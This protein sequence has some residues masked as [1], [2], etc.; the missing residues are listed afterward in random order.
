MRTHTHTHKTVLENGLRSTTSE[1][2]VS[3]LLT[4]MV[5]LGRGQRE[6]TP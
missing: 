6:G 3:L 5:G 4:A 1:E 2:F